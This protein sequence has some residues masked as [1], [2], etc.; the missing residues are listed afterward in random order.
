MAPPFESLQ[1]SVSRESSDDEY[2][3]QSQSLERRQA[4]KYETKPMVANSV[5]S[6]KASLPILQVTLQADLV[7]TVCGSPVVKKLDHGRHVMSSSP[8]PLKTCRVGEVMFNGPYG[9][10]GC[11]LARTVESNQG[12]RFDGNESVADSFR[13]GV[14]S[15]KKHVHAISRGF[16]PLT[17]ARKTS[18]L[19]ENSLP[20]VNLSSTPSLSDKYH[21]CKS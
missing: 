4:E 1:L 6:M 15:F 5:P 17:S 3:R 8:V 20:G 9:R 13:S 14:V 2:T 12:G 16:F 11:V 21:P 18:R 19:K 7:V 10:Q